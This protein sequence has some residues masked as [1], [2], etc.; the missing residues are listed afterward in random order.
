M[1]PTGRRT[2]RTAHALVVALCC[3][4]ALAAGFAVLTDR[5]PEPVDLLI[6]T[7]G[8]W[9][10][11][12][13]LLCLAITPLRRLTDAPTL[14]PYRRSFGLLAFAYALMHFLVYAVLDQGLA[15]GYL[16]EDVAE[17]PFITLGFAAFLCL[18]PLAITSTRGWVRRLGRRWPLL[19]RLSY[20]A[21]VGGVVPFWWGVKSDVRAP[22]LYAAVLALL[23]G[24]RAVQRRTR[25]SAPA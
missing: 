15:F 20:V 8:E 1:A 22:L 23:L 25:S 6:H 4:P 16:L 18:V 7:S 3:V 5:A 17:R 14:A 2:R 11:R 24:Y 21:A 10:L 13:L 19:H 12:F 9:A